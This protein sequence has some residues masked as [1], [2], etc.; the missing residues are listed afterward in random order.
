MIEILFVEAARNVAREPVS[1]EPD[2]TVWAD[3]DGRII[4]PVLIQEEYERLISEQESATAAKQAAVDSALA[5]LAA[6]GLTEEEVL[7][8]LGNAG[9]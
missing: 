5:K 8:L 9:V 2:L 6:L 7:A 3:S 4:D 1:I